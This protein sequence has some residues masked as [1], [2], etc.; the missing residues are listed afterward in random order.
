MTHNNTSNTELEAWLDENLKPC[1]DCNGD[2]Y[3]AEHDPSDPHENGCSHCPVQ[4]Q[5]ER[6]HANG[7]FVD[8]QV[9]LAKFEERE[10]LARIQ[11]RNLYGEP[12]CA[13][14]HHSKK[15]QHGAVEDCPVENAINQLSTNKESEKEV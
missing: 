5:C 2:G 15:W 9:L 10:R 11:L 3:T 7:Y 1:P 6:C 14:L 12:R 8:R 13:N 4:V